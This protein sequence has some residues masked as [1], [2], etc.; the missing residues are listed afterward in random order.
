MEEL[1]MPMSSEEKDKFRDWLEGQKIFMPGPAVD[2]LIAQ[3]TRDCNTFE[4][5]QLKLLKLLKDRKHKPPKK[6]LKPVQP[7]AKD[8]SVKTLSRVRTAKARLFGQDNMNLPGISNSEATEIAFCVTHQVSTQATKNTD[9]LTV[10]GEWQGNVGLVDF[11]LPLHPFSAA[12][13]RVAYETPNDP[14]TA[15]PIKLIIGDS[16]KAH[17]KKAK[18]RPAVLTTVYLHKKEWFE[19]LALALNDHYHAYTSELPASFGGVGRGH[20][21]TIPIKRTGVRYPAGS[22]TS[23]PATWSQVSVQA[24]YTTLGVQPTVTVSHFS[25]EESP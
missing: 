20:Q 25:P 13:V 15:Y 11:S 9:F 7:W 3:L 14:Q 10:L 4:Q 17:F 19:D 8:G 24:T 18:S 23:V 12:Q 21:F 1:D 2:D 6:R 16:A 5:A 22:P